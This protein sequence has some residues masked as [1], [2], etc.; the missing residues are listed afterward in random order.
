MAEDPLPG[1]HLGPLFFLIVKE[2]F[3]ALRD[4]DRFWYERILTG[5]ERREVEATRLS[6]VIRRNTDI[7]REI[8]NDVFRVS[9]RSH[10]GQQAPLD[11]LVLASAEAPPAPR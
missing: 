9:E 11:E 1:S 10:E 7:G 6:D 2:Q 4:G 5:P 8:P 3:E